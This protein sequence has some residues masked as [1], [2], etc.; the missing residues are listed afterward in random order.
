M[1]KEQSLGPDVSPRNGSEGAVRIRR[2]LV[3]SVDLYEIK[4][5]ELDQFELGSPADLQLNFS[6]FLLSIA[7]SCGTSIATA[8]FTNPKVE[9][10][11]YVATFCGLA[12][13]VFLL[14]SWWKNHTSLKEVC[15]R[16]RA[17]IRP[18]GAARG[19]SENPDSFAN[20]SDPG[21]TGMPPAPKG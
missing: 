12:I 11:F 8:S 13:G 10:G 1:A 6:I 5:S 20:G 2:G 16:I 9:I 15:G 3:E 14:F 4:D 21:S 18:E 19:A 7:L 17:R